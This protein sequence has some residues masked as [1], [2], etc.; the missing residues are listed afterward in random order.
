M[1]KK[2]TRKHTRKHTN[3]N[4]KIGRNRKKIY[5][6][7]YRGIY[8][9]RKVSPTL[10]DEEDLEMYIIEFEKVFKEYIKLK[11]YQHGQV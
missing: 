11:K 4:N 9:M 2:K 8:I 10:Q 6:Y 5:V 1:G 7:D 3:R